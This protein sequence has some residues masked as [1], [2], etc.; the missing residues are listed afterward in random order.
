[1]AIESMQ[2]LRLYN[3]SAAQTLEYNPSLA[4]VLRGRA[5][6]VLYYVVTV[7]KCAMCQ[8]YLPIAGLS[9]YR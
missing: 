1:M 2:P 7:Q 9:G 8:P 3:A 6:T 5:F 4:I